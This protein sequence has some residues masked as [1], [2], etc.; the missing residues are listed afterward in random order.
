LGAWFCGRLPGHKARI[1]LMLALGAAGDM[2]S[3]RRLMEE[4]A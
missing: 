1:K 3:A 4:G 2:A